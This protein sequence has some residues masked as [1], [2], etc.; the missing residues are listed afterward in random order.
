MKLIELSGPEKGEC[1]KDKIYELET[2]SRN[3]DLY[4]GINLRRITN[5]YVP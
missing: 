2:N 4:R 3:R 1:L 5:P